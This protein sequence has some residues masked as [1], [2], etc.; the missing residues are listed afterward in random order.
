MVKHT[1]NENILKF[2]RELKEIEN[3]IKMNDVESDFEI[4]L[5]LVVHF[6]FLK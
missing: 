3:T 2:N 4:T 5:I 6:L 1:I